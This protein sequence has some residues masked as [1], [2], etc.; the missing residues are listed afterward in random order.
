MLSIVLPIV[1]YQNYYQ[2]FN[3]VTF[4]ESIN[5]NTNIKELRA[6]GHVQRDGSRLTFHRSFGRLFLRRKDYFFSSRYNFLRTV[7]DLLRIMDRTNNRY[8][9]YT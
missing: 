2:F 4:N 3:I 8:F 1:L 7:N 9:H 5:E 6:T